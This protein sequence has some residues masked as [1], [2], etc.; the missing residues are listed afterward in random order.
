MERTK[1]ACKVLVGRPKSKRPL[2]RPRCRREDNSKI[3][4]TEISSEDV[5]WIALVK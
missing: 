3:D 5:V 1:N 4:L 2:G